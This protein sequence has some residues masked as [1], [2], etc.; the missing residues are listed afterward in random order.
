[1]RFFLIYVVLV[2]GIQ[3]VSAALRDRSVVIRIAQRVLGVDDV[4]TRANNNSGEIHIVEE[5]PYLW[6]CQSNDGR[7]AVVT[8][9]DRFP[10]VI[11]LSDDSMNGELPTGLIWWMEQ[12]HE[13]MRRVVEEAEYVP[14]ANA[15]GLPDSVEPFVKTLWGQTAPFNTKCP[16]KM[17]NGNL[18][19]CKVGCVALAMGQIMNYYRYPERGEGSKSYGLIHQVS[20]DFG[21]TVYDWDNMPE[22]ALGEWTQAQ[23]D[24]VGTLL[25]HCGVSVGTMYGVATSGVIRNQSIP[26]A[27]TS[28]FG[29]DATTMRYL[30][31]SDYAESAW[32][33]IIYQELAARR[34]VL[35]TG[36]SSTYGGHAFVLDGYNTAGDVHINWGWFGNGNG[37]YNINL[38]ESGVD[39]NQKQAMVCGIQLTQPVSSIAP[40]T[41]F[42]GERKVVGV[43]DVSGR[44]VNASHKGIRLIK[45]SD[46]TVVKQLP[47]TCI[48]R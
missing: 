14:L 36:N 5:K 16:T 28:Y 47:P 42:V 2:L 19:H 21:A 38:M 22:N 11:G 17:D 20:A 13:R 35:Y 15:F 10:G 6:V 4:S 45:Y 43:Y 30:D 27:M 46:G 26:G 31:R 23:T 8:T 3:S 33:G 24:A 29:Y 40:I 25:F 32:L 12:T 41:S 44:R 37:Y 18:Q 48:S 9:D 34:P 7:M 39:F 1:M